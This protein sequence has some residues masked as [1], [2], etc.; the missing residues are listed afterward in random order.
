MEPLNKSEIHLRISAI[1]I[2]GLRLGMKRRA[3]L[4]GLA[5]VAQSVALA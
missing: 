3:M 4:A 5:L 2:P 1:V